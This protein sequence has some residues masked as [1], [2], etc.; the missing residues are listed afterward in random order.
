MGVL[1]QNDALEAAVALAQHHDAITGTEMQHVANDYA[2]RLSR[3]LA[4][5]SAVVSRAFGNIVR[6]F[7]AGVDLAAGQTPPAGAPRRVTGLEALRRLAEAGPGFQEGGGGGAHF[8]RCPELN[9]S[10]CDVTEAATA[11]PGGGY[12]RVALWNPTGW[13]REEFV[14]VPVASDRVAV[15]S[16]FG[17][18]VVSQ[19]LPLSEATEKLRAASKCGGDARR[20]SDPG[21]G[22]SGAGSPT[23]TLV[24]KA[25]LMPMGFANFI[26]VSGDRFPARA[27]PAAMS[28]VRRVGAGEDYLVELANGHVQATFSNAGGALVD[29]AHGVRAAFDPQM[30]WYAAR[31]AKPPPNSGAYSFRPVGKVAMPGDGALTV[32]TGPVVSEVRRAHGEWASLEYRLY[33]GAR[34]LEA[35]WTVGPVPVDDGQGKE[36]VVE[37]ATDLASGERFRTDANGR[38]LL[39]RTRNATS[40]EPVAGNYYPMAAAAALREEEGCDAGA[41]AAACREFALVTDR[42][43]GA[44]SLRPGQ[45]E[46]MLHRRLLVENQGV[47]EHLNETQCGCRECDCPGLAARGAFRLAVGRAGGPAAAWRRSAQERVQNPVVAAFHDL[48]AAGVVELVPDFA[49][50]GAALPPNVGLMTLQPLG[51]CAVLLRLAH[52]YE[53][54]EHPAR[55]RKARVDLR[56]LVPEARILRV[57]ELTLTANAAKGRGEPGAGHRAGL[58]GRPLASLRDRFVELGPMEIRTFNLTVNFHEGHHSACRGDAAREAAVQV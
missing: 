46:V 3:G 22:S 18:P 19:L 23:F 34:H 11:A 16:G 9:I 38:D 43:Q 21:E 24:F 20:C 51:P 8:A 39:L 6:Y 12:V 40:D 5:S 37:F 55:S 50:M 31:Q 28:D 17:D 15:L 57:E 10:R 25:E 36:V 26:V 32:V 7:G 42:G 58:R 33:E 2:Q 30:H 4:S 52:L 47:R 14:R 54:G 48:S 13:V 56:A 53:R 49:A 35:E 1:G 45:L 29:L 44:S 27:V 41:G